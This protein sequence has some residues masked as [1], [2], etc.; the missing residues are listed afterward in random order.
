[1]GY[2]SKTK[3]SQRCIASL[4]F[5]GDDSDSGWWYSLNFSFNSNPFTRV[6]SKGVS[7]PRVL[8]SGR[9]ALR[10]LLFILL[11]HRVPRPYS[12]AEDGAPSLTGARDD[13]LFVKISY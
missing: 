5:L 6:I 13:G 7:E 4:K 8:I 10:D 3:K 1:M 2:C 11:K 9:V 12:G